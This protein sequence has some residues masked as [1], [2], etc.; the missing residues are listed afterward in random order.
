MYVLRLRMRGPTAC[1]GFE[2]ARSVDVGN[3]SRPIRL[4]A[5][6]FPSPLARSRN[7]GRHK[8]REPAKMPVRFFTSL[9]DYRN[10]QTATDHGSNIPQRDSLV[11][12]GVIPDAR[13][14]LFEGKPVQQRHRAGVRRATD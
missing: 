7:V 10:V 14:A 9:I 4:P 5:Q 12:D 8:M 11:S 2:I 1:S 13:S 3:E 6:A